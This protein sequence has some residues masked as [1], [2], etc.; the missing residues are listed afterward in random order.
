[1]CNLIDCVMLNR[2]LYF[3]I[4]IIIIFYII[5]KKDFEFGVKS[6]AQAKHLHVTRNE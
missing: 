3:K 1:M 5:N 4:I 6:G 2:L